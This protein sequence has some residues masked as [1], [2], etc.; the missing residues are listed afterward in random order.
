MSL[1]AVLQEREK[2]LKPL[3]EDAIAE[4]KRL[5]SLLRKKYNFDAIYIFG[6]VLTERFRPGSDI[7][8]VIKGINIRDFF[9]AYAFIIKE[10]NYKIDLKPFEDLPED[11]KRWVLVGG[12]RIE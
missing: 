5:T 7:D 6:S 8:L 1:I 4:A 3:R 10:S 11:F 9:R 12:N 2:R